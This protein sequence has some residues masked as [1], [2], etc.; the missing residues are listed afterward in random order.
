MSNPREAS[1][2]RTE[3]YRQQVAEWIFAGIQAYARSQENPQAAARLQLGKD[4]VATNAVGTMVGVK[5]NE[6]VAPFRSRGTNLSASNVAPAVVIPA[7]GQGVV[8]APAAVGG[9]EPEVRKALPVG[10]EKKE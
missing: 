10:T 2:L 4:R 8:V 9:V 7:P 3:E 1:L 6:E 5:K